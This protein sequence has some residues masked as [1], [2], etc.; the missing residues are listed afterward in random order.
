MNAKE[1]KRNPTVDGYLR[2]AK[3][4]QEEFAILRMISL[5]CGLSEELKWGIPC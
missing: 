4:W 3:K 5:A 2:R 1:E